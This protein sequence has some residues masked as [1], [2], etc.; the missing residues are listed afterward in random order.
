MQALKFHITQ[1]D[2]SRFAGHG[3]AFVTLGETMLRETPADQQRP[4]NTRQVYLALAG[5]EYS[6]ATLLSRLGMPSAYVSRVPDNP[7]GWMLRDTGRANGL[8]M[9]YL[10]WAPRTET[11]GRYLYEQGHTPRPGVVWYQRM[12]S[13]ASRLDRGMVDW[14]AALR[15]CKLLHA[16]GIT[17]GLAAH[18]GYQRNYLLD[19]FDDALAHKPADCLV[20]FDF[21]YRSTLWSEDDCRAVLTPLIEQHVDLLIT[22]LYDMAQHYGIGCGRYSAQEIG[23]GAFDELE[24]SDLQAFGAEVIQR[25]G[26]RLVAIT[27]RHAD[28][29]EEHRWEAAAITQAGDFFRS[30]LPRPVRLV[31]RLG[32]GDAW[33]AGFY[34][35]LLTAG[36][37]AQGI[38]KGVLV[39]DAAT[40]LKQTIMFDLPLLNAGEI[41][42]L[43]QSDLVGGGART[44]R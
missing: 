36:V 6:I 4:E 8:N 40:R 32:A 43:M 5:S 24:D 3:P 20:G 26:L 33:N 13:A 44:L 39:G 11:V 9:D 18:S 35:G 38:E 17:F 19:A 34:Y 41:E 29:A 22:S 2:L 31:E 16:S 42:A 21:N 23:S 27:L 25:F 30:P 15:A 10:V 12:F 37:N 14:A 28:S 7:Y 1:D